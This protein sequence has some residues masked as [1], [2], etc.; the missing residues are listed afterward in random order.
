MTPLYDVISTEPN[1]AD[2][3]IPKNQMKL[4]MCFG[5]SRHYRMDSIGLRHFKETAELGKVSATLVE[6]IVG[7]VKEQW[8]SAADAALKELE[9]V[10]C[11]SMS[12]IIIN[13]FSKR[14]RGL[15]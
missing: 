11:G 5:K 10:D 6:Q 4:A 9:S 7:D 8:E 3:Q 12:E 2:R 15:L 13:G 1:Y 14:L